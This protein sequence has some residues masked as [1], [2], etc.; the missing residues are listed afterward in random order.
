MVN[1]VHTKKLQSGEVVAYSDSAL[2]HNGSVVEYCRTSMAALS[3]VSA[4]MGINLTCLNLI[5]FFRCTFL[6]EMFYI[7]QEFKD[8]QD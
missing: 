4:G 3:G 1:R 5:D 7:S 6:N 2:R 8:S